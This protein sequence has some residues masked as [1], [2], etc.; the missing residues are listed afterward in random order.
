M[1]LLYHT[2]RP[3]VFIGKTITLNEQEQAIC[4][5]IAKQRQ[6]NN[7]RCKVKNNNVTKHSDYDVELQGFGGEMAFCK[8]FNVIPD[9]EISARSAASDKGDCNVDGFLIDVKTTRSHMSNLCVGLNKK[10][11]VF[12]YALMTGKFPTFTY[13]G[14]FLANSLLVDERIKEIKTG[15][16]YMAYQHELCM[17]S[18]AIMAVA[19]T[20]NKA[21]MVHNTP[22]FSVLCHGLHAPK[23]APVE[24]LQIQ[25]SSDTRTHPDLSSFH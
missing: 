23:K 4:H 6:A 9:F 24:A 22:A 13:R 8:A 5:Y 12:A 20:R 15:R 2:V 25:S 21:F 11:T 3:E 16:V 7:R 19:I 17:L 1:S 10:P 14:V 18:D